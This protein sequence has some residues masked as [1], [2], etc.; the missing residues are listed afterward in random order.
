[1]AEKLMLSTQY[2]WL[3][4]LRDEQELNKRT[5]ASSY[6]Q[7]IKERIQFANLHVTCTQNRDANLYR[8]DPRTGMSVETMT[9]PAYNL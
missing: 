3:D 9:V 8:G 1:M 4:S 5:F 7:A 2:A 6:L